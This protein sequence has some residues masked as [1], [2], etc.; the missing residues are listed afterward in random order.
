MAAPPIY[1]ALAEASEYNL[2]DAAAALRA[3][4]NI[5]EMFNKGYAPGQNMPD[6]LAK[7]QDM[8]TPDRLLTRDLFMKTTAPKGSN[9]LSNNVIIDN[10]LR[11][12][13]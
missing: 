6:Y 9:K 10:L 8:L 2:P 13:Q 5:G 12:D 4:H 7:A 3:Y 11:Y 1:S